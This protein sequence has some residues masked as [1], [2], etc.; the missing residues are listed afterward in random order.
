MRSVRSV[1]HR[2]PCRCRREDLP[3]EQG[4]LRGQD[5]RKRRKHTKSNHSFPPGSGCKETAVIALA[6]QLHEAKTSRG[7]ALRTRP[8]LLGSSGTK[9]PSICTQHRTKQRTRKNPSQQLA[10]LQ[11]V[12][13]ITSLSG[14]QIGTSEREKRLCLSA[15]DLP[16][17]PQVSGG[18]SEL[19]QRIAGLGERR[20]RRC[21]R[22]S[23]GAYSPNYKLSPFKRRTRHVQERRGRRCG[24]SWT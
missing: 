18:G 6:P 23:A 4:L 16:Q 11:P 5:L 7:T 8:L 24:G 14:P 22:A 3:S 19:R 9:S 2:G 12:K 1:F 13:W 17:M 21:S 20:P 15:Q 10:A